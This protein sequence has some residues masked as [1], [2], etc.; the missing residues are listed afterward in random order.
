MAITS[1]HFFHSIF[2]TRRSALSEYELST[3]PPEIVN[4]EVFERLDRDHDSSLSVIDW[5][6]EGGRV[7]DFGAMLAD[8]DNDG[9]F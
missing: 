1:F 2:R 9:E 4:A 8:H 6:R 7:V 5:M 3:V